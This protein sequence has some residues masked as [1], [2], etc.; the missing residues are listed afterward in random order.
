[1]VTMENNLRTILKRGWYECV[2]ET[3][4]ALV[5]RT[6]KRLFTDFCSHGNS[7]QVFLDP[8]FIPFGPLPGGYFWVEN[9]DVDKV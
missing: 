2:F 4:W 5:G 6:L 8:D 1:M 9:Q 7:E 3:A